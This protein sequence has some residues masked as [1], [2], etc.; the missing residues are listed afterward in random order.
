M[1]EINKEQIFQLWAE[2][3]AGDLDKNVEV[4]F[5]AYLKDHP[6]VAREL[7]DNEA[8]WDALDRYQ[9]T[10]E[11][12]EAMDDRFYGFL[13][14]EMESNAKKQSRTLW[15]RQWPELPWKVAAAFTLIGIFAGYLLLPNPQQNREISDLVNE[16]E[17]MKKMMMLTLIEQ[18]KAGERIRAV[19]M[20]REFDTVDDKVI[21]VLGETLVTDE[22]VNV[23]LAAIESLLSYWDVAKAREVLVSSI[24]QQNS[25]IVQSAIAD[26]MMSLRE[27]AAI[28]PL[29]ELID[30][31][32]LEESIK[33][34]LVTTV[35]Q[36]QSI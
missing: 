13:G 27:K 26:A 7:R 19:S 23:R 17:E 36:L 12:S 32:G 24:T 5:D 15:L 10:P 16:V 22:N 31:N 30:K 18:P 21:E 4:I 14:Q 25:P 34:K 2:K 6:E 28:S 33:E 1:T 8:I 35:D 9:T 11:P 3:L 29:K 20:A